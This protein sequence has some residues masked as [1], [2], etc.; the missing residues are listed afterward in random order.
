MYKRQ[1]VLEYVPV[2][3][4]TLFAAQQ[5]VIHEGEGEALIYTAHV[6]NPVFGGDAADYVFDV[7]GYDPFY[8]EAVASVPDDFLQREIETVLV[9]SLEG[10]SFV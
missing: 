6:I 1:E 5:V 4:G 7:V 10:F 9:E 3:T 8:D 2:L